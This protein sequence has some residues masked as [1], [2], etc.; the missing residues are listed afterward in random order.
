MQQ[1][2]PHAGRTPTVM[3]GKGAAARF[4]Y[5]TQVGIFVNN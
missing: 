4:D 2:N 3:T 1:D 5:K